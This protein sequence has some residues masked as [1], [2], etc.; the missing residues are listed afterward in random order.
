MLVICAVLH[1][2]VLIGANLRFSV[3]AASAIDVMH[4]KYSPPRASTPLRRPVRNH[5]AG[6]FLIPFRVWS[7]P[8]LIVVRM[9]MAPIPIIALLFLAGIFELV[10]L[11]VVV[12]SNTLPKRDSRCR[13]TCGSRC[14]PYRK[15]SPERLLPAVR[16]RQISPPAPQAQR[17]ESSEAKQ[18]FARCIVY[19]S[20][21]SECPLFNLRHLP[22]CPL[23]IPP[24]VQKSTPFLPAHIFK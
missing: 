23:T 17:L 24:Y 6:A 8:Y 14:D 9:L 21:I 12:S 16:E 4:S 5:S 3:R 20:K 15:T 2:D 1:P 18:R 22:L 10:I 11:F 13:P 7:S 19:S